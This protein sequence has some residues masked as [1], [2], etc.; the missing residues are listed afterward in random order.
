MSAI[1]RA[2]VQAWEGNAAKVREELALQRE[3]EAK[4]R[5]PHNPGRIAQLEK[6]LDHCEKMARIRARR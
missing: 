4:G 5:V 2:M 1:G 6:D 3:M